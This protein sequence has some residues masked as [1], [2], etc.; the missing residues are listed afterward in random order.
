MFFSH[1][2]LFFVYRDDRLGSAFFSLVSFFLGCRADEEKALDVGHE[3][4]QRRWHIGIESHWL[5]H[6]ASGFLAE[7]FVG[8]W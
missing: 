3:T 6:I 5:S 8:G 1:F 7:S 4:T 2:F